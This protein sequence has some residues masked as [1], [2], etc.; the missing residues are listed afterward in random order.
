MLNITAITKSKDS[1]EKLEDLEMMTALNRRPSNNTSVVTMDPQQPADFADCISN[2]H[3][4]Q[5]R[6]GHHHSHHSLVRFFLVLFSVPVFKSQTI[7]LTIGSQICICS[8]V[9]MHKLTHTLIL[10]RLQLETL[11]YIFLL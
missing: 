8:Y 1:K 5:R 10:K 2:Q 6:R 3:T 7:G 9:C 4:A 11:I